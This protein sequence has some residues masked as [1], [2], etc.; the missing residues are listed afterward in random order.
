M[1]QCQRFVV[2]PQLVIRLQPIGFHDEP[3]P[4]RTAGHVEFDHVEFRQSRVR[5]LG[6]ETQLR[7][8]APFEK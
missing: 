4:H 7:S 2:I 1:A 8:L 6:N 5:L 3:A